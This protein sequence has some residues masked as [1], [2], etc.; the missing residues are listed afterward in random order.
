MAWDGHVAACHGY[1]QWAGILHSAV[2]KHATHPHAWLAHAIG[3]GIPSG[4]RHS[5]R[6]GRCDR[7]WHVKSA[8]LPRRRHARVTSPYWLPPRPI[9]CEGNSMLLESQML[10]TIRP[11]LRLSNDPQTHTH[12]HWL[13]TEKSTRPVQSSTHP[14]PSLQASAPGSGY[15]G[16][17]AKAC[18]HCQVA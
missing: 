18:R 13:G 8:T 12:T 17:Q 4:E 5:H 2:T 6:D 15:W 9:T 14:T 3:R 10:V 7:V 11:S 16:Q 1:M